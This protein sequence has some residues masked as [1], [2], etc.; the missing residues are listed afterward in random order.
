[1]AFNPPKPDV[2]S[3]LPTLTGYPPGAYPYLPFPASN[4]AGMTMYPIY[5]TQ[6]SAQAQAPRPKRKQVKIACTNCANASKRCG[7][8]PAVPQI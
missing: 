7:R 2:T 6:P 1:M 4:V 5:N 8:K 3:F